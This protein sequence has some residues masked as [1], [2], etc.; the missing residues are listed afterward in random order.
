MQIKFISWNIWGGRRIE[1]VVKFLENEKPDLVALQEVSEKEHDGSVYNDA[2]KIADSLNMQYYFGKAFTTDRHFPSYTLGNAVLSSYPIIESRSIELSGLP[3]Y[4][5]NSETE[6]RN[7]VYVKL[8]LEQ[9]EISVISTHLGFS[10]TNEMTSVQSIQAEKLKSS[11]PDEACILAADLNTQAGNKL[12]SE[13]ESELA[14][15]NKPLNEVGKSHTTNTQIPEHRIDFVFTTKDF[16]VKNFQMPDT[17]A[18][19]HLPLVVEM[20]I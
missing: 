18:S 7:A 10:N 17:A 1:E 5:K 19:D 2:A 20:E 11:L 15:R 14:A 12:Y 6:P 4:R 16:D 9:K 13:L 3:L 8:Q